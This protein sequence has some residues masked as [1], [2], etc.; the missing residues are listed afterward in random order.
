MLFVLVSTSNNIGDG[1][2]AMRAN[3]SGVR[4][5]RADERSLRVLAERLQGS[6]RGIRT[7]TRDAINPLKR[8]LQ[9]FPPFIGRY[10]LR[11]TTLLQCEVS[12]DVSP[13]GI[14]CDTYGG[15]IVS[16]VGMFGILYGF[17]SLVPAVRLNCLLGVGRVKDRA[18]V[19]DGQLVVRPIL[20][21]M[22]ALGHRVIDGYQARLLTKSLTQR[23]SDPEGAGL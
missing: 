10:R 6:A 2:R 19:V 20:S 7:G 12:L 9:L 8:A 3:L 21:L 13:F 17:A 16:S 23:L 11:L 5:E 22:A 4:I 18:V 14:P 1:S 15:A